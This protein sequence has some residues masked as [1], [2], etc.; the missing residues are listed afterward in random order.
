MNATIQSPNE[1]LRH[2][3]SSGCQFSNPVFLGNITTSA[4][5]N[6]AGLFINILQV[7]QKQNKSKDI[8]NFIDEL[9]AQDP[10]L[11]SDLHA[12]RKLVADVLYGENPDSLK[13]LRLRAGYSQAQLAEKIHMKQPNI[14]ELEAGK[15]K[16][17]IE[18]LKKLA[19]ALDTTT[20]LILKSIIQSE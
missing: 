16:P 10:K 20:D 15:R 8:D 4:A 18:T 3:A 19:D 17:N 14:C 6:F 2:T 13:V 7:A 12:G 11:E 5:T 9:L 1:F